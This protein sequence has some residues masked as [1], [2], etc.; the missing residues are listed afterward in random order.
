MQKPEKD[1]MM[2]RPPRSK[3][4]IHNTALH[5][6][7]KSGDNRNM[8][9]SNNA[10]NTGMK[11]VPTKDK[12]ARDSFIVAKAKKGFTPDETIVLMKREGF[13]PVGRSTIYDILEK[14]GIKSRT[15]NK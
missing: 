15:R 13:V 9:D 2:H 7:T 5:K 6:P 11:T 12:S 10:K 14:H 1:R 8:V 3:A 4:G